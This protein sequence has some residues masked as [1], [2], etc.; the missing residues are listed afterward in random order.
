VLAKLRH[1]IRRWLSGEAITVVYHPDYRLPL[2]SFHAQTGMDSRRA[3]WVIDYLLDSGIIGGR[4]L[5]AP[6]RIRYAELARVHTPAYLE[7]VSDARNLAGVLAV[8]E[9]ELPVDETL[10]ALRLACGGT[11]E[12]THTTL[13]TRRPAINLL[14]GFHHAAPSRGGGFSVFNDVAVAIADLRRCGYA[15]TIVVLDLDAHPP[16][17][18]AACLAEVPDTWVGSL[19][20]ADWGSLGATDETL[21]PRQ[22]PD[23]DYLSAAAALLARMPRGG[24][25]FVVAGGDVLAGDHL[26][27]LALTLCG[28]RRRDLMVAAALDG[29]PSVWLPGGGYHP[30]AWK[31][32]AGTV[33]AVVLRS[34]EPVRA[35][36]TGL[37]ARFWK[38]ADDLGPD[39]L[40][41]EVALT[42]HEL[43]SDLG[44][45]SV[46]SER[47]L[48]YYTAEGIE[49]GLHRYGILGHLRRLGFDDFR[50]VIGRDSSGDRVRLFGKDAQG[51]QALVD[52]V[53]DR[54]IVAGRSVLFVNWLTLQNPSG[55]FSDKRAR[56][57]GQAAPGL[58]LAREAGEVLAQVARRLGLAGFAFTPAWYHT[59]FAA[60][61]S[62]RFVSPDVQGRFEALMEA[63]SDLPLS[64]ATQAVTEGRVRLNGEPYRWEAAV[65]VHW[66]DEESFDLEAVARTRAQSHFALRSKD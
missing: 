38:I 36:R 25:A 8:D 40:E 54:Q 9:S 53:L 11:L 15:E 50:V 31:L 10:G 19:S 20:G 21:L 45:S 4:A 43:L 64:E 65:M 7:S 29:T 14:G 62:M 42:E 56:L 13:A 60:R 61:R 34:N 35:A 44:Q 47:L 52:C 51:E 23:E 22:C 2:P 48:G 5:I 49:Y 16:D 30:D 37:R 55:R 33:I 58:G 28:A 6:R 18:I 57:P 27:D 59:A 1:R 41:G 26:G 17:G 63:L 12:A 24:V 3:D 66:L 46:Y 39:E 32:L